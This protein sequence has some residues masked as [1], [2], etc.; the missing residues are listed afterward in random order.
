MAWFLSVKH[1]AP[2]SR[3]LL[4]ADRHWYSVP[5]K[6]VVF[7]DDPLSTPDHKTTESANA[8]YEYWVSFMPGRRTLKFW[9]PCGR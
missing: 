3:T 6:P 1:R 7:Q 8:T 9:T 2:P 5:V 4:F